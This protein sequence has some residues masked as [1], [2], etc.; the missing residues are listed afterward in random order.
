MIYNKIHVAFGALRKITG[1]T[2]NYQYDAKQILVING[3]NLPEYYVV[4]FCNEGDATVIPMTGTSDGVEIPD[5][6][7]QTGKPVKAYIV[8]SSGQGDVQ[9]RYEVKLP[10]NN[11]PT[12][13]DIN[14]TD[15][16][17][18]QIDALVAALNSGVSKAE[19]A[20]EHYPKIT[21]G[22]WY[23]WDGDAGEYVST[24]IKAAGTD[25]TDGVSP[26]VTIV[27]IAGGHRITITDEDHPT[28]Q[29]FDVLDGQG[30][31]G[32]T[33]DYTGLTN[34]P[35][36]NGHTLSGNQSATDLGLGT[37]SK[38]ASG[39]P[40][41]D[42]ASDV[43]AS[44]GKADTALQTAPVQSVNGKTGAVIL[45]AAD[46]GAKPAS[47]TAP[48]SSVNGK[49]GAVNL[50]SGD[51]AYDSTE[52]YQAGTVGAELSNQSR[53][54]SDKADKTTYQTVTGTTLT[55]APAVDNTM[56]ICGELTELTVTA[57]ATGIF[58]IRFTSGTTPTV[59]SFTGIT[60]P[61]DWP[62]TLD[63]STTYE[64]NVLNGY[65]VWQSWT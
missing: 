3:L 64:I 20:V 35:Q 53:Q 22:Y 31:G 23:V 65:G 60:M 55:L 28:G 2:I 10:V 58:G 41:T 47:Y 27:D 42:L 26:T 38:P 19:E 57:L 63:A 5:S 29:S 32:G 36:I 1:P 8:V 43:Q 30:G 18:Q 13:A 51:I 44:L 48:V 56:Y 21:D 17:Q 15:E 59:V 54:L 40:K 14:P 16:Q 45:S 62:T 52:T 25:G 12:R 11:R 7:L 39:I 4:D 9:T 34:K 37:Y 49:T 33:S 50:A 46:V 24:D 61:D 6:L